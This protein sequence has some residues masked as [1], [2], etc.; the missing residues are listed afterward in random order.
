MYKYCF[1]LHRHTHTHTLAWS[2][3]GYHPDT[4][5]LLFP[6][7]CPGDR[8]HVAA[9]GCRGGC[10]CLPASRRSSRSEDHM[11]TSNKG[12][13]HRRSHRLT[14]IY[15]ILYSGV[16]AETLVLCLSPCPLSLPEFHSSSPVFFIFFNSISFF[17]SVYLLTS[18]FFSLPR[19]LSLVSVFSMIML[20][21]RSLLS[22]CS[23]VELVFGWYYITAPLSS[24]R[25]LAR[26][27]R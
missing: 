17:L 5:L 16:M 2:I 1:Y 9:G 23:L 6:A 25:G 26:I 19:S 27:V 22:E 4:S 3:A 12:F 24:Q 20:L 7:C 10:W 11:P 14:K 15:A 13:V 18:P 21:S 8:R